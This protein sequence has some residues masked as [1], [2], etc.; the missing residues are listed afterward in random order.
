[1]TVFILFKFKNIFEKVA[2]ED[3]LAQ[4]EFGAMVESTEKNQMTSEMG[5]YIP[6]FHQA[7]MTADYFILPFT[8]IEITSPLCIFGN[9]AKNA[10]PNLCTFSHRQFCF[11]TCFVIFH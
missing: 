10:I 1:M 3:I 7:A 11:E 4:I 6:Y 2:A 9:I 8:S 5:P